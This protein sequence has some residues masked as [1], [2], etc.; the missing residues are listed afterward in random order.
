MDK[1]YSRRRF[2]IKPLFKKNISKARKQKKKLIKVII[3]ISVVLLLYNMI[4]RYIEPIFTSMSEEKTK[5]LATI[6]VNEQSTIA[7]NKYQYDELFTIEKDENG[8]IVII[9]S[10]VVPMNN[11]IS[12][13]TAN[14]QYQFN[15]IEKT[16]I[17][18]PLG[19]L[20]GRYLLSG[21]GPDIPIYTSILGNLD[22]EVKSEFI[23]KGINQTL[24]RVYLNLSCKMEIITPIKNFESVIANQVIIAEHV[25]IGNIPESYYNLE[26]METGQ[27]TLEV[28]N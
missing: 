22:T 13:L 5:A 27:D 2:L 19:S 8:E 12:D 4:F 25:I 3:I 9:K 20:T 6:I 11:M 26:G 14:I 1:I 24:H 7:M 10:N 16:T 17:K 23:H 18:I 28:I 21:L 15:D